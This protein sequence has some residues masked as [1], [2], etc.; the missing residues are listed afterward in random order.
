MI[1]QMDTTPL[2]QDPPKTSKEFQ[3][4]P[5]YPYEPAISV[6][7]DR[8]INRAVIDHCRGHIPVTGHLSEISVEFRMFFSVDEERLHVVGA[9]RKEFGD[10]KIARL[11]HRFVSAQV[12]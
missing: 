6:E 8:L 12:I 3:Y 2:T 4:L 1:I 11:P 10:E 5:P 7:K 9:L